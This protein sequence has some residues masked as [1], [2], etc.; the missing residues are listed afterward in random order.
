MTEN[1]C[2]LCQ[3]FLIKPISY[4]NFQ[5]KPFNQIKFR[6]IDSNYLV[7]RNNIMVL[8]VASFPGNGSITK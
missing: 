2:Y 1:V 7:T 4:E 3:P 8:S 5:N 6:I